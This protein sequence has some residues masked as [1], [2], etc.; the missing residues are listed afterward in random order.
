MFDMAAAADK[1]EEVLVEGASPESYLERFA[2][3]EAKYPPHRPLKETVAAISETVSLLAPIEVAMRS[4]ANRDNAYRLGR[5]LTNLG[6][7]RTALGQFPDAETNLVEA[8]A[9]HAERFTVEVRGKDV[10]ATRVEMPF[11]KRA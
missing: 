9:A 4:N 6:R 3:D 8:H 5:L 2:W 11:Y 7:S 10:E 1:A